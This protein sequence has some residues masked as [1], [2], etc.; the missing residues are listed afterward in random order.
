MRAF[1]VL[2]IGA[3]GLAAGLPALAQASASYRLNEHVFNSGGHP[4]DGVVVSSPS[5][6]IRLDAIG[7]A[8]LGVGLSSAS[9]HA[10]TGFAS[11]Y[12]PPGEV[13]QLLA[14]DKQTLTWHPE[15]SA[16]RYNLYRGLIDTL[17]G[18]E[19]GAC[20]RQEIAGTTAT[21]TE[22]P[23]AFHAWFYLVTVENRLEEEGTKGYGSSAERGGIVCP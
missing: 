6:R 4:A 1:A 16:G 5:Y 12:P 18:L 9:F 13:A 3:L 10:E 2:L 19:Y 7:D 14:P 17:P 15:R 20:F 22:T 11:A 23:A 8:A 21:D